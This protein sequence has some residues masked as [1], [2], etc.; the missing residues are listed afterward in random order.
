VLVGA[1]MFG[2][3]AA[4]G[5]MFFPRGLARMSQ[6]LQQAPVLVGGV[7]LITVLI[8]VGL[9][10]LYAM[11]L[12]FLIPLIFL[13]LVMVGWLGIAILSLIGWLAL[14]EPFG[15]FIFRILRL[16]RQPRMIMAA[17][18]GMTLAMLLRVWSV[19][20]Y[21]PWSFVIS[22]LI[23]T[24]IGLGQVILTRGGTLPYTVHQGLFRRGAR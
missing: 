16:D 22:L 4:L 11:L 8:V 18:G 14:A 3:L 20:L 10:L 13:P 9:S 12:K 23:F 6:A 2:A 7:G 15:V 5:T 17:V 24:A 19:F 1:L 21:T